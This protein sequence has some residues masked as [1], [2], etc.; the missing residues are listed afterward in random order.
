MSV[1]CKELIKEIEKKFPLYIAED[2]DNSGLIIGDAEK[3]IKRVLFCLEVNLDVVKEA[4]ENNIDIII[5][6]HPLIFKPIKRIIKDNYISKAIYEIIKNDINLYALHTNFDNA[7]GGMNYI[8]A[9]ILELDNIHNLSNNK[10]EELYKLAVYVPKTHYQQVR[11]AL[12]NSSC[13]HIGNYSC[14]SFNISGEG[15]FMPLEGTNP[16]IGKTN[17]LEKVEEIKIETIVKERDIKRAVENMKK[18]HPYEEVAYDIYKLENKI[19][20]GTG[21]FGELK[22]EMY[23]D[24]LCQYVK[25]K[26]NIPSLNAAGECKKK[27]KR[28]AVVGG[29]GYQF[30]K[31]AIK[32]NCDVLITGD[33]KHHEAMD[34]INEGINI[35]DAGHYFTEVTAIPYISKF[36]SSLF[37]IECIISKINTNPFYRV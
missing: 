36:I 31:D 1:I 35:I 13:G 22:Y 21:V 32:N 4:V 18:V 34:A 17:E 6:H 10:Y 33:V 26:L 15:T 19:N 25:K 2:Y 24:E 11:E 5:S 16:Y 12:F 28:V 30:Y 14:C 29:S 23:F 9:D 8:L 37:D 7:Q 27:I 20:H 3:E